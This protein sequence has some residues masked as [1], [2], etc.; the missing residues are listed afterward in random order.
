MLG[1]MVHARIDVDVNTTE[2]AELFR[3][4][5]GS[6]SPLAPPMVDGVVRSWGIAMPLAQIDM[7]AGAADEEADAPGQP[8]QWQRPMNTVALSPTPVVVVALASPFDGMEEKSVGAA[9][10]NSTVQAARQR[11][12]GPKS[13]QLSSKTALNRTRSRTLTQQPSRQLTSATCVAAAMW[14]VGAVRQEPWMASGSAAD[15]STRIWFERGVK[16][17]RKRTALKQLKTE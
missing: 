16:R 7:E 5:T 9:E 11:I 17:K 3:L 8:A 1:S 12:R 4:E 15:A 2:E 14:L 6:A 10:Q 13:E